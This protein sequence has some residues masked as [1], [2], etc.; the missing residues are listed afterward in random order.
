VNTLRLAAVVFQPVVP[1]TLC[2]GTG[3][4]SFDTILDIIKDH[5]QIQLVLE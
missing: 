2:L 4:G 5:D 3:R 1:D